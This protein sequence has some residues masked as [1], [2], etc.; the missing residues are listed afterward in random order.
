[1][2][3]STR[4]QGARP[5]IAE[6]DGG[7]GG[8]NPRARKGRDIARLPAAPVRMMFQSTRPQGARPIMMMEKS[9]SS[10]FQSTRPQGARPLA[11]SC[12]VQ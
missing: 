5:D 2:F 7:T 1:M 11:P 8:F 6:A 3:Q 10:E 4:P 9:G 12:R